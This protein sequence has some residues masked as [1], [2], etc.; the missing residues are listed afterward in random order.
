MALPPPNGTHTR[1]VPGCVRGGA[2]LRSML[3]AEAGDSSAA[4]SPR[5]V[6]C[7]VIS[8]TVAPSI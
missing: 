1:F 3:E 5:T 4:A 7:V 8:G 6:G 2:R